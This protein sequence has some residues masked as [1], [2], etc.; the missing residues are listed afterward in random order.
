MIKL[1][2]K[3]KIHTELDNIVGSKCT[4]T[5][6]IDNFA[7]SGQVKI[8][9]SLWAARSV[10]DE[11]IYEVGEVLFVTAIEGVML[12]CRSVK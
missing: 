4:V 10:D 9:S 11:D 6:L 1:F 7:G 8:G 5:E 12:V 2:S 3:K